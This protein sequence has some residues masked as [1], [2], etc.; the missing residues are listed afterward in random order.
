M[1]NADRKR[2]HCWEGEGHAHTQARAQAEEEG[3]EEEGGS[4]QKSSPHHL[5]TAAKANTPPR[6]CRGREVR[7]T[8]VRVCTV[9]HLE[10]VFDRPAPHP[11]PGSK[12]APFPAAFTARGGGMESPRC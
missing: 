1:W 2:G 4:N 11:L 9:C 6:G 12:S 10:P 3:E 5:P 8:R 7:S